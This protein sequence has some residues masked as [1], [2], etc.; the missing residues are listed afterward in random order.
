MYSSGNVFLTIALSVT[1]LKVRVLYYI[2]AETTDATSFNVSVK[3][4]DSVGSLMDK[5]AVETGEGPDQI[6]GPDSYA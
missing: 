6:E 3:L 1:P 2:Q 4:S 5:I